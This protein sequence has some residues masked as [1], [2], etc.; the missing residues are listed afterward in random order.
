MSHKQD[1]TKDAG[2][3]YDQAGGLDR[4][5]LVIRTE[6]RIF[7]YAMQFKPPMTAAAAKVMVAGELPPDSRLMSDKRQASCELLTYKSAQVEQEW[8]RA[9]VIVTVSLNSSTMDAYDA[10]AVATI[11]FIA[12]DTDTTDC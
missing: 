8:Q 12:P 9:D 7:N 11:Y 1:P 3:A 5:A 2:A 10:Q 4:Y 6:G